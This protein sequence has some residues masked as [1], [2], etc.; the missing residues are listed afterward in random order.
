M[1]A[2]LVFLHFGVAFCY[3]LWMRSSATSPWNLNPNPEYEPFVSVLIPTYNEEKNIL[4]KLQNVKQARYPQDK[5]E[6]IVVDASTDGTLSMAEQWVKQNPSMMTTLVKEEERVGK[7]K[8][9]NK[10]LQV[11][12]GEVVVMTD[13]DCL[14]HQDALKSAIGYLADSSVR[15]VTTVDLPLDREG[16]PEKGLESTYRS[17]LELIKLGESKIHSTP[18]FQGEMAL[19][20]RNLLNRFVDNMGA[21]DAATALSIVRGG[22]RAIIV[23]EAVVYELMPRSLRMAFKMK[24]RRA[25]H[26]IQLF[27]RYRDLAL[28]SEGP[29]RLIMSVESYLHL[30]NPLFFF[31]TLALA[32]VVLIRYP[33]CVIPAAVILV[34]PGTRALLSTWVIHN[35]ALLIGLARGLSGGSELLWDKIEKRDITG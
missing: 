8:A 11:S 14:W 16:I 7:G 25:Q 19:F 15:C 9:L 33:V 10:G 12:K 2:T 23:P 32:A 22:H 20:K 4:R 1:L 24:V 5:M 17:Y 6:L 21:D 34:L 35:M 13:A 3:Y 27:W 29:L 26:L 18:R 28:S 31:P 30:L